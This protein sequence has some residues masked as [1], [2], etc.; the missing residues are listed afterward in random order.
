VGIGQLLSRIIAKQLTYRFQ[1]EDA[2]CLPVFYTILT[3][4][5]HFSTS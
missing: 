5:N 4:C 3:L 1:Q 2:L